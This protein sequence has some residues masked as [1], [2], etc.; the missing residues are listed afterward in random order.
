MHKMKLLSP[1]FV[2][3]GLAAS[4]AWSASESA[5]PETHLATPDYV[6]ADLAPPALRVEPLAPPR[7][8]YVW[9][10][11]YW[12]YDGATHV[13][14]EGHYVPDQVGMTYIAPRWE[15]SNGHYRLRR[16]GWTPNPLG[17]SRVNPL[18]PSPGQ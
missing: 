8:G 14:V 9:A 4:P 17:N 6:D 5:Y 15:E 3:A 10:P 16:E 13:W 11:G 7:D 2:I 12:N 1:L 18:A